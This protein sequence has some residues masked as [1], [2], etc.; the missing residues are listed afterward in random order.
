MSK[1]T[2]DLFEIL[3]FSL[4]RIQYPSS[5]EVIQSD[6]AWNI[7]KAKRVKEKNRAGK[8]IPVGYVYEKVPYRREL[9]K[10]IRKGS[11]P[12]EKTF[13]NSLTNNGI[14]LASNRVQPELLSEAIINSFKGVKPER[15][16]FYPTSAIFTETL[17][18]M[19]KDGMSGA[20]APALATIIEQLYSLGFTKNDNTEFYWI[21]N[22]Q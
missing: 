16:K 13:Y 6:L 3:F 22:I 18:A 15:G 21:N 1:S 10:V 9:K 4:N 20:S 17:L 11:K 14:S 12:D 8:D 19:D 5:P 7:S 2:T